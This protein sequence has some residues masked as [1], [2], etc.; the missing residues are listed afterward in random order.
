MAICLLCV[1][2]V[3]MLRLMC[4][5]SVFSNAMVKVQWPDESHLNLNVEPFPHVP[6]WP[7]F[8]HFLTH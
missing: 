8:L 5:G 3:F 6:T 1:A 4:F 2:A 7:D